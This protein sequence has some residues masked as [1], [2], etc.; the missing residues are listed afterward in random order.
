MEN[1]LG[2]IANFALLIGVAM[3]AVGQLILWVMSFRKSVW[4]GLGCVFVPGLPLLFAARNWS[5]TRKVVT[6]WG[7]GAILAFVAMGIMNLIM[8]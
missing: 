4:W 7:S 6:F 5:E 1:L 8:N 3:A 2:F